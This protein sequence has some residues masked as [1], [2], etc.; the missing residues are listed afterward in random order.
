MGKKAIFFL[1][2]KE[3]ATDKTCYRAVSVLNAFSKLY[4]EVLFDQIYEAFYWRLC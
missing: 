1:F 2:K 4:E 3:S